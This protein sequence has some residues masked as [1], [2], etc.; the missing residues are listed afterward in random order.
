M[1]S[2]L[3]TPIYAVREELTGETTAPPSDAGNLDSDGQ[4]PGQLNLLDA[5]TD[6]D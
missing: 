4:L 5:I 1:G 3:T 2:A 6:T